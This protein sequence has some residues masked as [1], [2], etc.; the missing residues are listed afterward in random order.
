MTTQLDHAVIG[1]NFVLSVAD[2]LEN[3]ESAAFAWAHEVKTN[4][5]RIPY[6]RVL[7]RLPAGLIFDSPPT[8]LV[9]AIRPLVVRRDEQDANF[10]RPP[11]TSRETYFQPSHTKQPPSSDNRLN[12]STVETRGSLRSMGR[13]TLRTTGAKDERFRP[14]SDKTGNLDRDVTVPQTNGLSWP[15]MAPRNARVEKNHHLCELAS[16]IKHTGPNEAP[17]EGLVKTDKDLHLSSRRS[18]F[19]HEA[20]D[21]LAHFLRHTSHKEIKRI[22]KLCRSA[23]LREHMRSSTILAKP[24]LGNSRQYSV[25]DLGGLTLSDRGISCRSSSIYSQAVDTRPNL[26]AYA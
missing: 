21:R 18:R 16:F 20:M 24:E 11:S 4:R 3:E 15:A 22:V 13:P 7:H 6:H 2:V 26:S 12:V 10:G 1:L 25:P 23:T 5:T 8:L 14:A 17:A 19:N 9:G